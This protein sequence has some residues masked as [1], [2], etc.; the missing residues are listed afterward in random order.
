MRAQM[1]GN[2][3]V[4]QAAIKHHE[5][6]RAEHDTTQDLKGALATAK[7]KHRAVLT[8]PKELAEI[9]LTIDRDLLLSFPKFPSSGGVPEGWG[10]KGVLW[11]RSN[12]VMR[13]VVKEPPRQ[14]LPAT[15]PREGNV[16][17][18]ALPATPPREG[19]VP[20]QALPATP[21]KQGNL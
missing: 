5:A 1:A 13:W 12:G 21:P 17:R 9:L 14:A 6:S 10:G 4:T 11:S 7:V 2:Q 16:P 20:R 8:N 19:N 3:K 18:Q 15:P